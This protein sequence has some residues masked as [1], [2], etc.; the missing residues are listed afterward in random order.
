MDPKIDV[1][2]RTREESLERHKSIRGSIYVQ[3]AR[4]VMKC[5]SQM[6]DRRRC[7]AGGNGSGNCAAVMMITERFWRDGEGEVQKIRRMVNPLTFSS[8]QDLSRLTDG[9]EASTVKL[10]SVWILYYCCCDRLIAPMQSVQR[11]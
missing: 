9:S 4:C 3:G 6:T 1:R 7:C 10:R 11:P 8:R 2:V 5:K